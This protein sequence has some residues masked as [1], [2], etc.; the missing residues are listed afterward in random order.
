MPHAR[1]SDTSICSFEKTG[2][3]GEGLA[4]LEGPVSGKK[5][6]ASE[7]LAAGSGA[8]ATGEKRTG[9]KKK[10]ESAASGDA[11]TAAVPKKRG[12]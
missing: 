1:N 2:V 8:A 5:R 10:G 3:V 7:G 12:K 6:R 9:G 11:D 4:A